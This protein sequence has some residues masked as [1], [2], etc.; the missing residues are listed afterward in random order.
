MLNDGFYVPQAIKR[1]KSLQDKCPHC[2]G[3][4]K[5]SLFTAMGQVGEK[6]L[7]C[8]APFTSSQADL[9][10]PY[11]IKEYYNSRGTRKLWLLVSVCN[12]SRF[13][14]ITAVESLSK[15]SILNAFENHFHRFGR[16]SYIETDLGTNFSAAKSDLEDVQALEENTVKEITQSLKSSGVSLIQRAAKSPW[17]VGGVERANQIVKRIFPEKRLTIFQC[18]N[19]LEYV[20]FYINQRPIGS[21]STLE[22]IKP[23]DIIPIWSK[24]QPSECFMKNCSKVLQDAMTEFRNKWENL[25]KSSILQ[26]KKWMQTNHDLEK[27]DIVLITDLKNKLNYPKHGKISNIE[28]DHTGTDR[29]FH[30]EYK[31]GKRT[32]SVKRTAQSLVLILKK[33]ESEKAKIS[34]SLFWCSD[35]NVNVDDKKKRIAVQ[36]DNSNSDEIL[37]L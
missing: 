11:S 36:T 34:D 27:D 8:S 22:C 33:S 5:R 21:S 12:F 37:D 14:S 19:M 13:I 10:G 28:M 23:A 15:E 24:L 9:I 30:I 31:I 4:I 17:I 26:Q 1:L 7:E 3:R 16:S 32:Q 2:R 20:M 29:Y 35:K 25:Y 18:L 6:R